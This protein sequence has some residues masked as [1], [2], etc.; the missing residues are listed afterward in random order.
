VI[1]VIA[2]DDGVMPQTR[3]HLDILSLLGV[4]HGVVVLTKADKVSPSRVATVTR[5]IRDYLQGT[6]LKDAPIYPYSNITGQGFSEFY[7]GLL[8]LVQRLTPKH[9]D[10]IFRLPIERTFSVKG[11]G[12][13]ASGIPVSGSARVGDQVIVHPSAMQ[14]RIKAIQVYSNQSE[15]VMCGQC[16]A[17]NVPQWDYSKI[18]RGD[19]ITIEG[20]F[21]PSDWCLCQLDM[22]NL[23]GFYLKN[24]SSV[25][26]HTGTS[27][28]TAKVYM[29]EGD[30]AF[31]GE[32]K[33]VQI[34]LNQ[35]IVA[36]PMDRFILRGLSPVQ[37]IG[38]GSI[39][40][41]L[42]QKLRRSRPEV[43]EDAK[44]RAIAVQ[45]DASFA[46]Y[47]IRTAPDLAIAIK[48]VAQRIKKAL[49]RTEGIVQA[50]VKSGAVMGLDQGLM[51]HSH[52]ADELKRQF[53][54]QISQYH[55]TDPA[56]PGMDIES[57]QKESALSKPIFQRLLSDLQAEFKIRI[58]EGRVCLPNHNVKFDPA[59]QKRMKEV[60]S[61]FLKRLFNP[62]VQTEIMERCKINAK[63]AKSALR[64]LTEHGRLVY[65]GGDLYFH[66]D[67]L[68]KAK[69]LVIDHFK[70]EK[71]LESVDFKYLI[72]A[73]RKYA[74]P[75]LDYFDKVGITKRAPD[76][77]RYLGPKA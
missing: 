10:G 41:A 20:W 77:T 14:G 24:G 53:L 7:E 4:Q 38:G 50:L 27:E 72:N 60:E 18:S 56:S 70:K 26:F 45:N 73:T 71:R 28:N 42:E 59:E 46:E 15:Q 39:I 51:L 13:I 52:T 16:A 47:V 76:N 21:A 58:Q 9:T 74:L 5:E 61:L 37:T 43:V 65:I 40:E 33:L 3:E 19:V 69:Q 11:Y 30:R 54:Y 1:F 31:S 17:I 67:A 6:F 62:P 12:T 48:A 64:L 66:S 68:A 25:K 23:E 49:P 36:A 22:L 55:K 63:D 34:Q 2:A 57:F 8:D 32:C 75:L 44:Q 35:P 29:L